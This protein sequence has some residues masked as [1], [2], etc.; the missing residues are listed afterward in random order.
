MIELRQ[1]WWRLCL[2]S[3][4]YGSLVGGLFF[5]GLLVAV[6]LVLAGLWAVVPIAVAAIA[7]FEIRSVRLRLRAD[8]S[9]I[10]IRNRLITH[11]VAWSDVDGIS[12]SV[13][14]PL[15][16]MDDIR[17]ILRI[18]RRKPGGAIPVYA[19]MGIGRSELE[20]LAKRLIDL[21]REN[22]FEIPRPPAGPAAGATV[23]QRGTVNEPIREFPDT[24]A[25][26]RR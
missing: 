7:V 17:P 25:A 2:L 5:G 23:P 3:P 18:H 8:G 4:F 16:T 6:A 9:G 14:G 26:S 22:G 24:T 11:H 10:H 15:M 19:A 1:P 21:G 13:Q 20:E 12:L